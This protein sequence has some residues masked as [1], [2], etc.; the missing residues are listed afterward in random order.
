ME[1]DGALGRV[2]PGELDGIAAFERYL[3]AT[4]TRQAHHASGEDVDRRNDFELAC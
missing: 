3:L 2:A 1:S 4:P